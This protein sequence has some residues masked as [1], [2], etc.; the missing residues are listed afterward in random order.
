MK[1]LKAGIALLLVSMAFASA[2]LIPRY[3]MDSL[4]ARSHVVVYC[5]ELEIHDRKIDHGKW[6][7]I[8]TVIKCKVLQSFKGDLVPGAELTVEYDSIYRR[9]QGMV[10][11]SPQTAKSI[12]AG[13][14]LLF[15]RKNESGSYI[16][17]DA[18]LVQ[19]DAVSKFEQLMNPGPL[20][21]MPQEA[22]NISLEAGKK[23]GEKELL[24]DVAIALKKSASIQIKREDR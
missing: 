8:R 11:M 23:Y 18:K 6:Q 2:A 22:E 16:V 17:Y 24:V 10:A 9:G 7:E 4:I 13:K 14:A 1:T 20:V 21:L 3:P 15:L 5:E 12:P 19:G